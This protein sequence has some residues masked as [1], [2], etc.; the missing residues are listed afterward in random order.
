MSPG[1]VN[2]LGIG[3]WLVAAAAV[4]YFLIPRYDVTIRER[5]PGI[6]TATAATPSSEVAS[7]EL[8]PVAAGAYKNLAVETRNAEGAGLLTIDR[9]LE[10]AERE[11][12]S[13]Y[14]FTYERARLAV[15]GRAEHHEAFYHLR[16]AAEKAIATERAREMLNRLEQDGGPHGRFRRLAI[17]H[18]EWTALR[19]ALEHID[20]DRLW[21][22]HARHR[23]VPAAARKRAALKPETEFAL[24]STP[25]ARRAL[26]ARTRASA[27]LE[28]G[29]PC[30]GALIA[31][32]E[33]RTDPEAEEVYH[34]L[35]ELCLLQPG[36][37]RTR[38]WSRAAG[39]PDDSAP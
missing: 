10:A 3:G 31:L 37:A 27:L 29:Q 5:G 38:H 25:P 21:H 17:G 2:A 9:R 22:E 8:E 16:R 36:A 15:Y 34:Y 6:Q 28:S 23:P 35:R 12:P 33:A 32:Q 14:R 18:R 26:S 20:R 39:L 19:D 24:A 30:V 13:D 11:F 4:I 1:S 7:G